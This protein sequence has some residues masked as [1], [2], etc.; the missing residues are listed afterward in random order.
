MCFDIIKV[1]VIAF[2]I[3]KESLRKNMSRQNI[4]L[5]WIYYD[6]DIVNEKMGNSGIPVNVPHTNKILPLQYFSEFDYQFVSSYKKILHIKKE[7][8]KLYIINFEG[9]MMKATLYVNKQY[10]DESIY[11]YVDFTVDITDYLVDGNNEII[12]VAD[13]RETVNVAPFGGL[14]DY[15]TFGGIYRDVTLLIKNKTY[16]KNVKATYLNK[17]LEIELITNNKQYENVVVGISDGHVGHAY[18]FNS[19]EKGK[20]VI[21]DL[22]YIKLWNIENPHLYKITVS[23]G[24]DVYEFNYGF[25]TIEIKDFQF[26]LNNK[27]VKLFGL[28]RHQSYP[29]I[30]YAST[31]NMEKIDAQILKNMGLNIVRAHYPQSKHF[32]DECDRL[33][34]LVFSEIPGW[35]YIGD[36]EWKETVVEYTRKIIERDYNH[37]SWVIFGVR[38]NESSDCDE[39][40]LKTNELARKLD[41][42]RFTTG[43][44]FF[45][46]SSFLEDIYS[47]NDF[48]YKKDKPIQDPLEV[49]GLNEYKPYLITE[50][51]GHTYPTKKIDSEMKQL[52]QLIRHMRI[53]HAARKSDK[54]LGSIGWCAFD[55]NT[56]SQFGSGDK[57]CYHGIMDIYR[58]PKLAHKFYL[59]QIDREKQ[60]ILEPATIYAHGERDGCGIVPLYVF[61]NCDDVK[62]ETKDKTYDFEKIEELN[63]YKNPIFVLN[64]MVGAWGYRWHDG[65]FKGFIDGREVI[66]KTFL[67]D[68]LPYDLD[69]KLYDN[70]IEL[71]DSTRIEI[72][73]VDRVS[74]VLRFSNDLLHI[75]IENGIINCP[76]DVA[77]YGGEYAFYVRSINK[78]KIKIKLSCL[79]YTKEIEIKVV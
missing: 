60:I 77:L 28:N 40:Y 37:P 16:I 36:D 47:F 10:V 1:N 2:I 18:F 31:K 71:N 24:S 5:N 38:I 53:H 46:N 70:K 76:N 51:A 75:E 19:E 29:H 44:R 6:Y 8:D 33:G 50:F 30:G 64:S 69:V 49:V 4:N 34:L 39:L 41:P 55:Y 17:Q 21:T 54:I 3:K 23:I 45:K 48:N 26:Y 22:D 27:K 73:L 62:L 25:R 56:H 78:D 68:Q 42:T 9:V 65:V 74:N 43:V 14:I 79:N 61:T 67:A 66:R 63:C 72:R 13:S 52:E 20:Y 12:V 7:N 59:G 35:Q 15:M 11:G 58:M 57:I 32:I